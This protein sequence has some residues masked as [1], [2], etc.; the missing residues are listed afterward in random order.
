MGS[1][2]WVKKYFDSLTCEK[3]LKEYEDS[4]LMF[5]WRAEELCTEVARWVSSH[6]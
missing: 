3:E 6:R 4:H 1:S 5:D 2:E